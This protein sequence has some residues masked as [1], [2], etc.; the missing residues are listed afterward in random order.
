MSDYEAIA[1]AFLMVLVYGGM[2]LGGSVLVE[3]E[4]PSNAKLAA[5]AAPWAIAIVVSLWV[6]LT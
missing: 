3:S 5:C 6:A 2:I 1:T 4:N